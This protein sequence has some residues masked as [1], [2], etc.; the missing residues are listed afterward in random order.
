MAADLILYRD[1][2]TGVVTEYTPGT[3]GG[4]GDAD[5]VPALDAAGKFPLAM[6]P[7]GVGADTFEA[8]ASEA[9]S[10]GDLI[11][12]YDDSGTTKVRKADGSTTGKIARGFVLA[13][14]ESA[15]TAT[16]YSAGSNDQVTGLTPGPQWLSTT[17]AGGVQATVP[18]GAGKTSQ[19]VGYAVTATLLVVDLGEPVT[20]A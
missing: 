9:L 10:A 2:T 4:A 7:T 20:L 6:M 14:V 16:V 3:T 12:V 5:K 19:R 13:A 18:S 11:D 17:T 8:T 1:G 15:A